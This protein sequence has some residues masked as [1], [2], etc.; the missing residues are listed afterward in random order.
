MLE[1]LEGDTSKLHLLRLGLFLI[2]WKYTDNNGPDHTNEICQWA[3]LSCYP[4]CDGQPEYGKAYSPLREEY[5]G[6]LF[7]LKL[8]LS[9]PADL[10]DMVRL[11]ITDRR[12][13][14]SYRAEERTGQ[15]LVILLTVQVRYYVCEYSADPASLSDPMNF[16][17]S[18]RLDGSCTGLFPFWIL[19]FD[20]YEYP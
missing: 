8:N 7:R 6:Q 13:E 2:P 5:L 9:L 11:L 1:Y 10:M 16:K 3:T 18:L 20:Q 15:K 12:W 19:I 4:G 14:R 17:L